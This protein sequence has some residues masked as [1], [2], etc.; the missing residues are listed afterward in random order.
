[1]TPAMTRLLIEISDKGLD[2]VTISKTATNDLTYRHLPIVGDDYVQ[3]L[4]TLVYDNPDLL[5]D[6]ASIDILF[7]TQR[8]VLV[9]ADKA[10]DDHL[11][12]I[13]DSLWPDVDLDIVTTDA[14]SPA[15][16][17]AV[18]VDRRLLSFVRRTFS[19]AR[20]SHRLRP[21]CR[22][23]ALGNLMRNTGKVHV[24][25]HDSRMDIIAFD[26]ENLL[27][28]NTFAIGGDS[29]ALY[30]VLAAARQLNFDVR[31][32]QVL[33]SG[34]PAT[35]DPLM[36]SLRQYFSNVMPTIFPADMFSR[37]ADAMQAPFELI[38]TPL[39]E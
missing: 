14:D 4:E 25:L 23:F 6:Y 1:M 18:A 32:D 9:P 28:A 3:A 39:C 13:V 36:R 31:T 29:D 16:V 10:D 11:R 26:G 21:L 5:A 15:T 19:Q 34:V 8:F 17:L 20:L 22:Y 30:Y 37:G 33:I 35:R 24:N 7:D 12:D 27:M 38:I 2:V